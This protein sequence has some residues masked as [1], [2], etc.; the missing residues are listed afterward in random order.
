MQLI[1]VCTSKL[2]T[3]V[4]CIVIKV[5]GKHGSSQIIL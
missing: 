5:V 3:L 1:L 4:G 2:A